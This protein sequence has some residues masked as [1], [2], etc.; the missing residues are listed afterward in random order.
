MEKIIE[1]KI[2]GSK[3]EIIPSKRLRERLEL[4]PGAPIEIEVKGQALV[5]KPISDPLEELDG[6][7]ETGLSAK[8]LKR[9]AE[10]QV[11]KEATIKVTRRER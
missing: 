2:L 11:M 3:G 8:E 4:K 10:L 9:M 5:V 1:R 7:L 6:V